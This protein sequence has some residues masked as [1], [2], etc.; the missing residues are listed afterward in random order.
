MQI[1]LLKIHSDKNVNISMLTN[2]RILVDRHIYSLK[3]WG[4][5]KI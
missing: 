2:V 5:L 4:K 3:S 1:I